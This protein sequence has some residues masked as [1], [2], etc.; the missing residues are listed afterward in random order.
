MKTRTVCLPPGSVPAGATLASDVVNA[1][2]KTLLTAGTELDGQNLEG[3]IR[4][5]IEAVYVNEADTRDL[6]TIGRQLAE[7]QQRVDY[8]FRGDSDH[9]RAELRAV[10]QN[11]RRESL[12]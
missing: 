10:I 8:I 5:G 4:R 2:G 6:T 9:A 11:F 1:H 3:L 7:A 12:Q